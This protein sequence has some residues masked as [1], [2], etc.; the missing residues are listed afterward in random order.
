MID[1]DK[2]YALSLYSVLA[3]AFIY[4]SFLTKV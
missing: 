3:L 2:L 1:G 4:Y